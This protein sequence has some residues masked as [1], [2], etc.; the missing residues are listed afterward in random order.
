MAYGVWKLCF[1]VLETQLDLIA[2]ELLD[3]LPDRPIYE[4]N[5][6]VKEGDPFM[7]TCHMSLFKVLKWQ[8]NN[9]TLNSKGNYTIS[10]TNNTEIVSTISVNSASPMHSGEYRCT[11]QYSTFH[12]L[13][14]ELLVDT[15]T[16]RLWRAFK[17][18]VHVPGPVRLAS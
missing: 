8:L 14:V 10:G 12:K 9:Q 1:F 5:T 15:G 3:E 11:T 18:Y 17:M 13:L 4:G 2:D 7:I 16:C 6:T